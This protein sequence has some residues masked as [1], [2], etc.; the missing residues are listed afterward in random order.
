MQFTY[1]SFVKATVKSRC[2]L[3]YLVSCSNDKHS[4][5]DEAL[6]VYVALIT[7]PPGPDEVLPHSEA[8]E[9]QT[10]HLPLQRAV[11]AFLQTHTEFIFLSGLLR[12]NEKGLLAECSWVFFFSLLKESKV[13]I[14]TVFVRTWEKLDFR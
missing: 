4:P 14:Q 10:P 3:H 11:E 6:A 8:N 12:R 1:A 2:L 13:F 5:Q 9:A 7:G